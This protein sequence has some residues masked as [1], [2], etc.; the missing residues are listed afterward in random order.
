[1]HW[2]VGG[3]GVSSEA[4]TAGSLESSMVKLQSNAILRMIQ[5]DTSQ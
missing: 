3:I 5:Y 1:M 2:N 4:S